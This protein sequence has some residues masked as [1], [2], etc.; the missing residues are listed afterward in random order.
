MLLPL[1]WASVAGY[2]AFQIFVLFLAAGRDRWSAGLPL[3]VMVPL[4]AWSVTGLVIGHN[5]WAV[6]MLL[7]APLAFIYVALAICDQR[8]L[9][10]E[11]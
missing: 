2:V 6:P 9:P 8:K 5:T 3:L 11:R 1:L 4:F 7:G 10:T